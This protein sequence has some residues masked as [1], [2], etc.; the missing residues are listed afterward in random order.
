MRA[1]KYTKGDFRERTWNTG[2]AR[3]QVHQN[4]TIVPPPSTFLP[5]T[6]LNQTQK[7]CLPF[8]GRTATLTPEFQLP[9][10]GCL[11]TGSPCS[12]T[13]SL[14][15]ASAKCQTHLTCPQSAVSCLV[16]YLPEHKR[17]H[18]RAQQTEST[19]LPCCSPSH[20]RAAPTSPCSFHIPE[21]CVNTR[22][23]VHRRWVTVALALLRALY[24]YLLELL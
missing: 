20:R 18:S 11:E 5:H 10:P 21:R 22:L 17:T 14:Q 12:T 24:I 4:T 15:I 13:A 23:P 16:C 6:I 8:A 9:S 19:A 7:S 3:V 2:I 1:Q